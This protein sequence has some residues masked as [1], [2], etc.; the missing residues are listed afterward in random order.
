MWGL[1]V[2]PTHGVIHTLSQNS[3]SEKRKDVQKCHITESAPIAAPISILENGVIARTKK[4]PPQVLPTTRA[5][6]VRVK[7]P[8][9]LSPPILPENK[10]EIKYENVEA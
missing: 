9:T 2:R 10:E 6:K 7:L 1:R 5:A 8:A 4:K 3:K